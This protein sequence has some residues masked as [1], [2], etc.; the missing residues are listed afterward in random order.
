MGFKVIIWGTGLVGKSVLLELL[1]HPEYEVVGVIV[2]APE[3]DGKDIGDFLN[4]PK[5]GIIASRDSEKVC[6]SMPM[7][8]HTLAPARFMLRSI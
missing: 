8:L 1:T 4:L 6:H 7:W 2:N 5:T 3:K